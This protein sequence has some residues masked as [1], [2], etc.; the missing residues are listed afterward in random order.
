MGGRK[1]GGLLVSVFKLSGKRREEKKKP[2]NK[3]K[4]WPSLARAPFAV[5]KPLKGKKEGGSP[6]TIFPFGKKGAFRGG[7]RSKF[8]LFEKKERRLPNGFIHDQT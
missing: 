7:Q 8:L 3:G 1:K 2:S 6:K 4:K 5:K